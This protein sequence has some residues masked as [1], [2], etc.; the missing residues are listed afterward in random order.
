[1]KSTRR[2]IAELKQILG[3]GVRLAV[4]VNRSWSFEQ[5]VGWM[6]YLADNDIAWLEEPLDPV[7][8]HR[9]SELVERATIPVS[10]GENFLIPPGT[11]FCTE[12]EWGLDLNE[13]QL[14]LDILQPAIVKNCC[15]SDAV[16]LLNLAEELGKKIYPHFLGSAPGMAASAQLASLTK[17]P[18]LEWDINPNPM[19]TFCFT[20]PFRAKNGLSA[21]KRR[22][23]YRLGD[24]AGD[25]QGLES[26]TCAG[27][28]LTFLGTNLKDR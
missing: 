15:F 17:Y 2:N 16:R 24:T 12:K 6:N 25:F 10:G 21:L 14:S 27:G 26:R 5:A 4:D 3:D 1:M 13:T 19:R 22:P 20:E 23:R 7:H 11:D 18:H 8:Q 9:Y 28:K